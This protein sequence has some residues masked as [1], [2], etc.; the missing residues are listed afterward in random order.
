MAKSSHAKCGKHDRGT[1]RVDNDNGKKRHKYYVCSREIGEA[2][3]KAK[4]IVIG[5]KRVP[6]RVMSLRELIGKKVCKIVS[7]Y[8]PQ[9]G[10]DEEE[11]EVF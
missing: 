5:V 3:S 8:V 7:A 4:E 9:V 2:G 11:K 10:L 6:D 1:C